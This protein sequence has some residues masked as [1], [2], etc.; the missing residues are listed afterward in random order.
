MTGSAD[1]TSVPTE[2]SPL[3]P[4]S[5]SGVVNDNG[6]LENRPVNGVPAVAQDANDNR[7]GNPEMA[8]KMHILLPAVG[9]GIYLCAVDQLLTVATYAK[10][11]SELHALQNTSW[12]ATAYYITLTSFQPLY[13]KLSDIFGRK[14]CL[15]FA[16]V[17]FGLGSLGCGLAQ[18]FAQLCVARAVAGIGGGGMNSVV[19]ILLSDIVPLRDR[20]VWQGYL[21]IIFAAGTSTGAPLGGLLA[22]TVG[23]RWSFAGQVPLC[24]LAFLAVYLVLDLPRADHARWRDKVRRIDFLGAATLVAAV[25]ALLVG[26]DSGSNN[27]WSSRAT[28][29]GLASAPVLFAVFVLVEMRVASHPFAPGHIIFDRSLFA[30][31]LANFFGIAGHIASIFFLP[32][33]FQAVRGASATQAG[34]ALVP[35]MVASVTASVSA[36]VWMKRSGRYYTLTV[37]AYGLMV[38]AVAPT[39]AALGAGSSAGVVGSMALL[40]LGGGAG[41]TTTLVALLS[42]AAVQDTAVVVACS[43]LFRSLGSSIGISVCSAVLQQVLRTQLAAR[44]SDGDEARRVEERVRES[45]DY[46]RELPP[47]VAAEVRASYQVATLGAMVPVALL[48]VLAFAS[49]FFIREK[50]LGK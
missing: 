33:F 38:L 32:L 40:A 37:L 50:A 14:E 45:L 46:I 34:A 15:L 19:A 6:P 27:G 26:L 30:C 1:G 41:I 21:N 44:L 39:V 42:N 36:G 2:T 49:T 5:D 17:I 8:K 7:D 43:Y 35:A 47:A 9:I 16:Y 29:A 24:A 12:L 20:G 4:N 13:G 25:V 31:Y 22:D 18:S 48:L 11:G 23:W 10:I 28:V 3:L